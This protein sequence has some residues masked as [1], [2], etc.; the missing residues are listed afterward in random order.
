MKA[1]DKSGC[2]KPSRVQA[3]EKNKNFQFTTFQDPETLSPLNLGI[4]SDNH[5]ENNLKG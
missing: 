5:Y 4:S 3:I 1:T 2:F